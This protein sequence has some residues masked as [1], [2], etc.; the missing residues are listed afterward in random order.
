MNT[1]NLLIGA[2][3]AVAV[4]IVYKK[5]LAPKPTVQTTTPSLGETVGGAIDS[6]KK[7]VDVIVGILTATVPPASRGVVGESVAP[8]GTGALNFDADEDQFG[9]YATRVIPMRAYA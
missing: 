9:Q 2:G 7:A 4:V 5:F 8:V 3:V 1:K 6:G